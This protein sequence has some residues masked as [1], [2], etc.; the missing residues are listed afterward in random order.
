MDRALNKD[1]YRVVPNLY[2]QFTYQKENIT[3]SGPAPICA[4]PAL[5]RM[6]PADAIG[7]GLTSSRFVGEL[8][9]FGSVPPL[10]K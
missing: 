6:R 5:V 1:L 7:N 9:H 4:G 2:T 10:K 8:N 3:P